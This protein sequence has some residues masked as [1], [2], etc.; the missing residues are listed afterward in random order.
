MHDEQ[1]L[2]NTD[3]YHPPRKLEKGVW[4]A[5]LFKTNFR[6]NRE[7]TPLRKFGQRFKENF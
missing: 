5:P 2:Q 7:F 6:L 4:S 3:K 1:T